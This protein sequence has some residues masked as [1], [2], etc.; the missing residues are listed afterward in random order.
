MKEDMSFKYKLVEFY[1]ESKENINFKSQLIL[2]LVQSIKEEN[3]QFFS[4]SK[5]IKLISL[6]YL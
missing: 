4:K 6:K 5:Q 3:N 2:S 1:E